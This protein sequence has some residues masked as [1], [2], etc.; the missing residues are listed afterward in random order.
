[1][2]HDIEHFE[3]LLEGTCNRCGLCCVGVAPDGRPWHCGNLIRLGPISHPFAT[4]CAVYDQ[5][6]DA[7]PIEPLDDETGRV[8]GTALCFLNSRTEDLAIIEK[9]VGR[10]CSLTIKPDKI[11]RVSYE[12]LHRLRQ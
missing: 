6:V 10:G 11:R 12:D 4:L 3:S 8:I 7:M 2:P 9:G 1:M 5:R